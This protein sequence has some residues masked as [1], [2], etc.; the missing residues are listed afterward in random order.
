MIFS[1]IFLMG[2]EPFTPSLDLDY[3]QVQEVKAQKS[4]NGSWSFDVTI[5]H[6]DQGWNHYADKWIIV[7]PD[8]GEIY[9][10]RVLAHPHDNEQPF[11]RSLSGVIIPE[12]ITVEVR[13]KCT[14]HGYEGKRITLDLGEE[15]ES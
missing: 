4:S 9:G 14:L 3:A 12:G 13:A 2:D 6:N 10:E 7:S 8:T 5:R 15:G 1:L 11:T